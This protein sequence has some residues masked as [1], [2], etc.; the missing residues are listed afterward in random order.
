[1]QSADGEGT[2]EVSAVPCPTLYLYVE[3]RMG[4][5]HIAFVLLEF[6]SISNLSS[7]FH[8]S[9]KKYDEELK[10]KHSTIR[11]RF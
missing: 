2:L 6:F 10:Q 5:G 8:K 9:W 11:S 7:I 3:Q 4:T 1:M